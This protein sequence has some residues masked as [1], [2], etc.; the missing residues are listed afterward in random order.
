MARLVEFWNEGAAA[1][2]RNTLEERGLRVEKLAES[3]DV[4][5][6][7][8]RNW[9]RTDKQPTRPYIQ[10][11]H[12]LSAELGLSVDAFR[13]AARAHDAR[14][15][16]TGAPLA[17]SGEQVHQT[18]TD[19]NTLPSDDV[20]ALSRSRLSSIQD[21]TDG[22]APATESLARSG[23]LWESSAPASRRSFGKSVW[24]LALAVI[25]GIGVLLWL[26]VRGRTA[27][28]AVTK[29]S[30][31][32]S[33]PVTF[34]IQPELKDVYDAAFGGDVS[35]DGAHIAFLAK[36]IRTMRRTLFVYSVSDRN[37]RPLPGSEGNYTSFF[38][39]SDSQSIFFITNATLMKINIAGGAP[40]RVADVGEAVKGTVNRSGVVILGSR[41]GLILVN[42]DKAMYVTRT[43]PGEVAHSL[44]EFLSDGDRVL[45]AITRRVPQKHVSRVLA[46]FSLSTHRVREL[47]PIPSRA[48]YVNDQ[49]LY[50][51]DRTL[52]ARQLDADSLQFS[53]PERIVASPVWSDT[54][55]GEAGFSASASTLMIS[56]AAGIPP[57]YEK[58]RDGRVVRTISDLQDI[59]Y[60]GVGHVTNQ[61]ALIAREDD[62]SEQGLW[63]YPLDGA[64]RV[65]L[66]SDYGQPTS[67]VFSPDDR[68]VYYADVGESWA[69]IYAADTQTSSSSTPRPVFLADDL[70]APRDVSPDGRFLLIQRWQNRDG[71]IW[72]MPV[73][74][75]RQ[76]KPF[77]STP[78]DEGESARFSPNGKR[79]AFVAKR[80]AE[81]SVYLAD[82][83]TRD[84][85]ARRAVDGEG[86]R[87]RWSMDGR[88]INF[89]RGK[90]VMET[91]LA[92]HD[93]RRLFDMEREIAILE[94]A[95]NG[96]FFVREVPIQQHRTVATVWWPRL[97][98]QP[99]RLT[100]TK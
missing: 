30:L 73:D 82:F 26:I 58:A 14:L 64:E 79:V 69:N 68:L 49:L 88:R 9:M 32:S 21:V 44:P 94:V 67:P 38:W 87:V 3:L 29:P 16:P 6:R 84:E 42:G 18:P 19:A 40:E 72:F 7:T 83:T 50:V 17:T 52:F 2:L 93:T 24:L 100:I 56:P 91:D 36:S 54:L 4:E 99:L 22:A 76:A 85:P 70:M 13:A 10:N 41:K 66:V 63:L 35:P 15:V 57:V 12:D 59:L 75:Q 28:L 27:P 60:V 55:T 77:V 80:G 95:R 43:H 89:A 45:F 71:N 61:L 46:A 96:N 25:L 98:D 37:T 65:Q 31:P 1:L 34:D 97:R 74:D 20:P 90:S 81:Y 5:P 39:D 92:T 8:I 33:P 11:L 78:E 53:G 86:W 47:F 51:R 23:P 48:R 62:R